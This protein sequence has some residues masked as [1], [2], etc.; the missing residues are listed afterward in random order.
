MCQCSKIYA[1][2]CWINGE[3]VSPCCVIFLCLSNGVYLSASY[4]D[5]TG[6]FEVF[7]TNERPDFDKPEGDNDFYYPYKELLIKETKRGLSFEEYVI[8]D[9]AVVFHFSDPISLTL[10]YDMSGDVEHL[11]IIT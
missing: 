9:N 4:N 10:S 2:E 5:E 6:K 7:E 11:E 8:H 1:R 3:L